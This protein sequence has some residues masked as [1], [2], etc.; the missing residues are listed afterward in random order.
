MEPQFL[1]IDYVEGEEG[2]PFLII[3]MYKELKY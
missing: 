1:M 3:G 2:C